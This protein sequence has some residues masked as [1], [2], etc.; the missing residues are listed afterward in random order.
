MERMK[1][2]STTWGDFGKHFTGIKSLAYD[3]DDFTVEFGG[4]IKIQYRVTNI[5]N[6]RKDC[7]YIGIAPIGFLNLFGGPTVDTK[8]YVIRKNGKIDNF[9]EWFNKDETKEELKPFFEELDDWFHND[10]CKRG[11]GA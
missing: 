4:L 10:Y 2:M 11:E 3:R 8:T 1:F 6:K 7:T 9:V 5:Y